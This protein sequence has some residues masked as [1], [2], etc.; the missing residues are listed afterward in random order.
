VAIAS[1]EE[2]EQSAR[3][4]LI[5]LASEQQQCDDDAVLNLDHFRNTR[6]QRRRRVIFIT[7]RARKLLGKVS[8]LFSATSYLR[9]INC[10][11][12]SLYDGK[13]E[14]IRFNLESDTDA[15]HLM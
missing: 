5:L 2:F 3:D 14:R 6:Q 12:R 7:C 9:L 8:F 10:V 11:V 4:V 1:E 15:Y 13:H